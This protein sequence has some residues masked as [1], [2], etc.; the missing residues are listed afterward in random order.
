M[1]DEETSRVTPAGDGRAVQPAQ[2]HSLTRAAV[3]AGVLAV[4]L[5]G[6][7]LSLVSSA[8]DPQ[9]TA[10]SRPPT[11]IALATGAACLALLTVAALAGRSALTGTH[12]ARRLHALSLIVLLAGVLASVA[13]GFAETADPQAVDPVWGALSSSGLVALLVLLHAR[14]VRR[15]LRGR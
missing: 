11:V 15:R 2:R 8:A 6:T 5:A 7:V 10:T 3:T 9:S 4:I 13:T 12:T 14:W 1:V